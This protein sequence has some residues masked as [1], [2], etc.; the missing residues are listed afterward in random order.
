MTSFH[1]H[2]VN[3]S[4]SSH[5]SYVARGTVVIWLTKI[6]FLLDALCVN[7]GKYAFVLVTLL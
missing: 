7:S 4:V 1:P 2:W 6:Q 3:V 5:G